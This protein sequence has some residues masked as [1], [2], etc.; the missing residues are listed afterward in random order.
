MKKINIHIGEYYSSSEPAIITT[1]LGPCVAVCLNDTLKKIGGM[2]HILLPGQNSGKSD[3]GD[4]RYAI[5]AIELL[6]NQMM[7]LGADRYR[8]KAKIFGGAQIFPFMKMEKAIGLT[9]IETVINFLKIENI[10][11]LNY[12]FGGHDPRKIYFYTETGDVLLQRIKSSEARK[13]FDDLKNKTRYLENKINEKGNV[14]YL[15]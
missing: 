5:N 10:P 7:K 1:I 2:N 3:P 8:L 4:A 9:N 11:I 6:I 14:F 13:E 12:N 15:D